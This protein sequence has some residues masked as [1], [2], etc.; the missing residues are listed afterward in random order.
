MSHPLLDAIERLSPL[1]FTGTVE[2][3]RGLVV[4]CKG[5]SS[6]LKVGDRCLIERRA[7]A[8]SA[9]DTVMAEVV[10][11][12]AS[13][14]LLMPFDQLEGIGPGS[15]IAVVPSATAVM[16]SAAWLG[17]VVNALGEPI[18]GK[19]LLP[20]GGIPFPVR[21]SPPP[22]QLRER[23]KGKL[24]L[25]VRSL[26]AFLTCLPWSADGDFRGLR[27]RKIHSDV[28]AGEIFTGERQRHRP[29]R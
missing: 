19:G 29:D 6:V 27:R 17:R 13:Y 20:S 16:P 3:V 14:A 24:D 7:H 5:L 2:T 9:P 21:A 10:G 22:A 15:K 12:D 8:G 23:V 25:G 18:D 26:N 11:F 28:D 4:T 1:R